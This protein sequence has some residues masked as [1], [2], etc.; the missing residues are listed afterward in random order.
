MT[1]MQ[2]VED[3]LPSAPLAADLAL[4]GGRIF[5]RIRRD[6]VGSRRCSPCDNSWVA[7]DRVV[8]AG[9]TG[10]LFH[11]AHGPVRSASLRRDLV[12]RDLSAVGFSVLRKPAGDDGAVAVITMGCPGVRLRAL[13]EALRVTDAPLPASVAWHIVWRTTALREAWRKLRVEPLDTFVGF[14]G[15]VHLFPAMPACWQDEMPSFELN[16]TFDPLVI[17]GSAGTLEQLL[18]GTL[19]G[20]WASD[21][22]KLVDRASAPRLRAFLDGPRP[23]GDH[24]PALARLVQHTFPGTHARHDRVMTPLGYDLD[25]DGLA[26]EATILARADIVASTNEPLWSRLDKGDD[27][28]SMPPSG[29]SWRDRIKLMTRGHK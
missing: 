16:D 13:L 28:P 27:E 11:G 20:A 18:C 26:R 6:T 8:L 17:D 12:D 10:F 14:D 19:P 9:R 22:R 3:T 23:T 24:T 5:E 25:S 15:S 29:A 1:T 7:V 21:P 2:D 4:H